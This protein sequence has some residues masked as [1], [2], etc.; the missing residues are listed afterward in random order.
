MSYVSRHKVE[1]IFFR[2]QNKDY[3]TYV[4]TTHQSV[5]NE[6]CRALIAKDPRMKGAKAAPVQAGLDRGTILGYNQIRKRN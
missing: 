1:V 6:Y 2:I 4:D 5:A 3:V